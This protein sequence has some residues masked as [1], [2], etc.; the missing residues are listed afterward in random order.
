M[1]KTWLQVEMEESIALLRKRLE[2]LN[3][4]DPDEVDADTVC[5]LESIYKTISMIRCIK[6][7]PA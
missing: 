6:K 4:L 1:D 2:H 7:E 3:A 5:E